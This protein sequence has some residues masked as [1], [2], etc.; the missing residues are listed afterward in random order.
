MI[1]IQTQSLYERQTGKPHEVTI[2]FGQ[3]NPVSRGHYEVLIDGNLHSMHDRK[4]EAFKEVINLMSLNRWTPI[5][6]VTE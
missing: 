2:M 5:N 3:I 1:H 4:R 6:R